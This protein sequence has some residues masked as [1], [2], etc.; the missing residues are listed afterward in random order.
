MILMFLPNP[1]FMLS[2]SAAQQDGQTAS[3]TPAPNSAPRTETTT[4]APASAP[5]SHQEVR[6]AHHPPSFCSSP[7]PIP[8]CL[9]ITNPVKHFYPPPSKCPEEHF[10][11]P[12]ANIKLL[13]TYLLLTFRC[14][15][16]WSQTQWIQAFSFNCWTYSFLQVGG[17]K[18][19]VLPTW[20]A[21][22]TPARP[23]WFT[24]MALS[25][26]IGRVQIWWLQWQPW[27][28]A[29]PTSDWMMSDYCIFGDEI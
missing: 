7:T 12:C 15:I 21:Y 6:S 3:P 16:L 1:A 14:C 18:L 13:L 29:L 23:V 24:I 22:I 5:S 20:T 2:A 11:F 9:F 17:L 4:A 19:V 25:G 10:I 8:V 28:C 26:T 27:W